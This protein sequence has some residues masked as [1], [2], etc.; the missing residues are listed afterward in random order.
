MHGIENASIPPKGIET[1][2]KE[3]LNKEKKTTAEISTIFFIFLNIN[4]LNNNTL[5]YGFK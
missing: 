3:N 2:A 1:N 5:N 4:I